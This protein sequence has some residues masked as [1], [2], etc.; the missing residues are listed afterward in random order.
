[1]ED[2]EKE[3]RQIN[4]LVHIIRSVRCQVDLTQILNRDAYNAMHAAHL[5]KLLENSK[6]LTTK[7]VHDESIRTLCISLPQP[8]CLDKVRSWIEE[9]LW[10]KK[11]GMDV[12]RC[13]GVFNIINSDK[14][15]TLQ[16]VRE[17][18]EIVPARTWE[19]EESRLNKVVFIGQN[20][21]ERVLTDTF[22][23]CISTS[24]YSTEDCNGNFNFMRA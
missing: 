1:M 19:K 16:A 4:S 18:Y 12:Y 2:L 10:D 5:D 8:V 11:Y 21:D 6:S 15:H 20:L 13:K 17:I 3:I 24:L 7:D 23:A 9:I 14:L 22:G